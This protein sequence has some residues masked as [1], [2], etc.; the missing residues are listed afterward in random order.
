MGQLLTRIKGVLVNHKYTQRCAQKIL[1]QIVPHALMKSPWPN[2]HTV[3]DGGCVA[4][5]MIQDME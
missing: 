4:A 2:V 1:S 3:M 5:V